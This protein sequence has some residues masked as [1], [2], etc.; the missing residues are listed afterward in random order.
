MAALAGLR[1]ESITLDFFWRN[2]DT[3][4][5]VV[6]PRVVFLEFESIYT[7]FSVHLSDADPQN[8]N[9]QLPFNHAGMKKDLLEIPLERFRSVK[10]ITRIFLESEMEVELEIPG[11]LVPGSAYTLMFTTDNSDLSATLVKME[12]VSSTI[13][14]SSL[15]LTAYDSNLSE[16]EDPLPIVDKNTLPE[17]LH[18]ALIHSMNTKINEFKWKLIH[19]HNIHSNA[20]IPEDLERK[21]LEDMVHKMNPYSLE[22]LLEKICAVSK[23]GESNSSIGYKIFNERIIKASIEVLGS[24]WLTTIMRLSLEACILSPIQAEVEALIDEIAYSFQMTCVERSLAYN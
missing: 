15:T 22:Q 18:G 4:K 16:L 7:K 9:Q 8:L 20:V 6:D 13:S 3:N 11:E 23:K 12:E 5:E 1:H 19:L 21:I 24:R 17:H 10:I 2:L 14:S